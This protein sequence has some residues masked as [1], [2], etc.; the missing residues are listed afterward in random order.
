MNKKIISLFILFVVTVGTSTKSWGME[1]LEHKHA[2][3][4]AVTAWIK[5][6][7]LKQKRKAIRKKLLEQ[8]LREQKKKKNQEKKRTKLV[9]SKWVENVFNNVDVTHQC[10]ICKEGLNTDICIAQH[11]EEKKFGKQHNIHSS[12]FKN[13]LKIIN[14]RL[15][16]EDFDETE[17]N[18]S[19]CI[20]C[21]KEG[22]ILKNMPLEER[23]TYFSARWPLSLVM[24]TLEELGKLTPEKRISLFSLNGIHLAIQEVVAKKLNEKDYVNK[25]EIIDT[26]I[27]VINMCE[28]EETFKSLVLKLE[29]NDLKAIFK[30]CLELGILELLVEILEKIETTAKQEE[31]IDYFNM[32][33]AAFCN[34]KIGL[35]TVGNLLPILT[36]LYPANQNFFSEK[37]YTSFI[38]QLLSTHYTGIIDILDDIAMTSEDIR[39]KVISDVDV[40]KCLIATKDKGL[41]RTTLNSK[42]RLLARFWDLL[43]K[44]Q[45]LRF[46]NDYFEQGDFKYREQCITDL[47]DILKQEDLDKY[48]E[49]LLMTCHDITLAA[50]ALLCNWEAIS[51][52]KRL[53]IF[54]KLFKQAD[55]P[56]KKTLIEGFKGKFD[57]ETTKKYAQ[58]LTNTQDPLENLSPGSTEYAK[59]F[60]TLFDKADA[61]GK[62]MLL[63]R[64]HLLNRKERGNYLAILLQE[65]PNDLTAQ[66]ELLYNHYRLLPKKKF[67]PLANT[68]FQQRTAEEKYYL[69][70]TLWHPLSESSRKKYFKE[71]YKAFENNRD[72][73][74]DILREY[75]ALW[76]AEDQKTYLTELIEKSDPSNS[77]RLSEYLKIAQLTDVI[78]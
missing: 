48:F 17:T 26:T 14:A 71:I 73:Q 1:K 4:T 21:H 68:L 19:S 16:P 70:E 53:Y 27:R 57:E 23:I 45:R 22:A 32:V 6:V 58:E 33:S 2:I 54:D 76:T 3:K 41:T 52:Q 10:P 74:E 40:V 18:S 15:V 24:Q 66:A 47:K 44:E 51:S 65:Y 9:I 61:A 8:K 42:S 63:N 64:P 35:K 38:E 59:T 67:L 29:D 49:K 20:T 62:Q 77:R 28:I 39:K 12:C 56:Q 72:V 55:K 37:I 30:E 11:P 50:T 7:E 5:D 60:K 43:P 46:F 25:K 69:L 75:W 34:G 13:W 78:E 31:K 36:S